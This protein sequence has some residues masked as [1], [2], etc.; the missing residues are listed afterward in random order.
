R[1]GD[2][3]RLASLGAVERGVELGGVDDREPD[4]PADQRARLL[5]GCQVG[6][7]VDGDEDEPVRE[8]ADGKGAEPPGIGRPKQGDGLA[9]DRVRPELEE[10]ERELVGEGARDLLARHPAP[11]DEE[12]AEPPAGPLALAERDLELLGVDQPG[13][14]EQRADRNPG[15]NLVHHQSHSTAPAEILMPVSSEMAQAACTERS[16]SSS[17]ALAG[18]ASIASDWQSARASLAPSFSSSRCRA[19]TRSRSVTSP[20]AAMSRSRRVLPSRNLVSCS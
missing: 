1:T 2:L 14:N 18:G 20:I 7:V 3:S 5:R 17:P 13:A 6:G 9:L 10:V 4:R 19:G 8:H 15:V 16:S 12:L 11:L